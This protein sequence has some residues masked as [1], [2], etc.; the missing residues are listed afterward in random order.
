MSQA[1]SILDH[2][3]VH[4]SITSMQAINSF[5]CTRL[6]ARVKDLEQAGYVIP[7]ETIEVVNRN[8]KRCRVTLYKRPHYQIELFS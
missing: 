1:Q 7:R 5:G 4:G 8:G 6:A 3:N 2:L